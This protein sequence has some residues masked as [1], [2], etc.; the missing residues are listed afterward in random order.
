MKTI[1]VGIGNPI[2]QD[3]GVGIHVMNEVQRHI[4]DPTITFE[5]AYTGGFNLLDILQGYDK[6]ILVD[7]VKQENS[8][9]GDVQR[10][11]LTE[12]SSLH[13]N[14]PH[15]VSLP[16]ALR[17]AQQLGQH[18]L[19]QEIVVIGVVVGDTSTFGDHLSTTVQQAIPHA[20]RMVL[21]ELQR[22][23]ERNAA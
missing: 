1:V 13:S 3:D 5:T 7:A 9:I 12:A 19:P 16:E 11:L 15:D 17:L 2:L 18:Q 23:R 20:V 4:N 6:A 10:F 22:T 14:N 8:R 21:S